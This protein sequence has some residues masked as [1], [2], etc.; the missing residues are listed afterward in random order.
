MPIAFM[1]FLSSEG[2]ALMG[3][4]RDLGE[5]K[6]YAITRF[7]GILNLTVAG[8]DRTNSVIPTWA[9]QRIAAA[10]NIQEGEA[11]ASSAG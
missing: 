10:W 1:Q 4:F 7:R 3:G 9:K 6:F 11:G 5:W 2:N 8:A